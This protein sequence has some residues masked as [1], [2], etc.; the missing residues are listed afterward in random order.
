MDA[1]VPYKPSCVEEKATS[2]SIYV[3]GQAEDGV[4]VRFTNIKGKYY[5]CVRD[6]IIATCVNN[7][8]KDKKAWIAACKYASGTWMNISTKL[9]KG[10]LAEY[11]E[12][13]KFPGNLLIQLSYK[14][15]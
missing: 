1:V 9:Q 13:F 8:K 11:L 14:A 15:L 2:C 4:K 3:N 12:D 6:L 7:P 5:I 10:E